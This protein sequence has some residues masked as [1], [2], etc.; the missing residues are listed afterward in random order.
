MCDL[1]KGDFSGTVETGTGFQIYEKMG[2]ESKVGNTKGDLHKVLFE[3]VAEK[4]GHFLEGG[5]GTKEA[6]GAFVFCS[7][8]EILELVYMLIG[9]I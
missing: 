6:G 3:R 1:D 5:A 8:N 2:G 4:W 9:M 7:R